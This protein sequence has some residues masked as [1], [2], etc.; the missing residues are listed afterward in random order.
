MR[1]C[2][3]IVGFALLASL[4]VCSAALISNVFGTHM[5]LQR[6]RDIPVWGWTTSGSS[7]HGSLGGGA[8]LT[9]TADSSGFW[10]VSFPPLAAGGG[11]LTLEMTSS[12]GET[13]T[14]VDI[15]MGDVVLCSGQ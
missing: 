1:S 3:S 9:T 8:V 14:L 6:G 2:S 12:S 5:V 4:H 15:L 7:V 13:A 11:P 10:R